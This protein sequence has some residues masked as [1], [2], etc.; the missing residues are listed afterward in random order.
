MIKNIFENNGNTIINMLS[1]RLL[2]IIK[3]VR[4]KLYI[5]ISV[6]KN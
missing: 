6:E 5:L 2:A 3:G 1:R 4:D